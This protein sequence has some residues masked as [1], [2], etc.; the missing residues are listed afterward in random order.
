MRIVSKGF[1]LIRDRSD[2]NKAGQKVIL[3][4]DNKKFCLI[5]GVKLTVFL[6]AVEL[7]V[8]EWNIHTKCLGFK[9]LQHN[10]WCTKGP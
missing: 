5:F 7:N 1:S 3:L 10:S 9:E 6:A 2:G 4:L 8:A